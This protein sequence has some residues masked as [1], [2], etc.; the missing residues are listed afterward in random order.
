MGQLMLL[1]CQPTPTDGTTD[2]G[3]RTGRRRA[4]SF[5]QVYI[6]TSNMAT[7]DRPEGAMAD[8]SGTEGT[9]RFF[10]DHLVEGV[11]IIGFDWTYRYVNESAA[12]QGE[13]TR[14]Q[15]VGRPMVACY[16]GIDQT[17]LFTALRR[18]MES[19]V[20]ET[21]TNEFVEPSGEHRWFELIIEPVPEGICV[22]SLDVTDRRTLEL[23]FQQAQKMEAVGQLAGG[24]AHDFN[25]LLTAILGNCDLLLEDTPPDHPSRE[26]L[27]EIRRAGMSASSLTAGLLAFSRKQVVEPVVLDLNGT[28]SAMVRLLERMIGED[29]RIRLRLQPDLAPVRI[30]PGQVDQVLMNLVVNGRDA[31]P[32]GGELTIETA[33]VE[34]DEQYTTT[35]FAV[36]GG[37]YVLLAVSDTGTGMSKEVQSRI[38]EPFFTTKGPGKGTGLGLA[39]VYGIVKQNRG[40]IWVYSEPGRGTTFKVYWPRARA[41]DAPLRPPA[42]IPTPREAATV[43]VV[44][45]NPAVIA[46]VQRILTKRGFTVLATHD[47]NEALE[48]CR[49]HPHRIDLLLSDVVMPDVS[50]PEL[51]GRLQALR[52]GMKV[53]FMSGFTDE[54]VIRHGLQSGAAFVQKPFTPDDIARKIHAVL[55]ERLV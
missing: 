45:D 30:D 15:L 55:G 47:P 52:P 42:A 27:E 17:P 28:V 21:M 48:L 4:G 53:L 25:N 18:V 1:A 36:V 44:E 20:R 3:G 24:V 29:I 6:V 2:G 12:R 9:L 39:G 38:F 33:N 11:Q 35:H 16:P 43:L 40:T 54:G 49:T 31:M 7:T 26:G 19:R 10:A 14:D 8:S 51:A 5:R 46:L 34:L 22:L 41:E 32:N 23:Q 13:R 37:P 50:G